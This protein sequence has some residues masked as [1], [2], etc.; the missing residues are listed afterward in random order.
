MGVLRF[1]IRIGILWVISL[2][3]AVAGMELGHRIVMATDRRE[4][5]RLPRETPSA[6]SV[7]DE[8]AH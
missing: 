2:L 8:P 4:M 3:V 6:V 7:G 5:A 1:V